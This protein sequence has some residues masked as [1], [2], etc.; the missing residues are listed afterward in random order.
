MGTRATGAFEITGW[1]GAPYDE[2]EGATLS[3][4]RLTKTYRGDLEGESA[5]DLLFAEAQEEGSGA[6]SG[7]ERFVGGV[8]GRAGSFV[9]QHCENGPGGERPDAATLGVVAGSGTGELRGLSGEARIVVD[10]EGNHAFT[11]YYDLG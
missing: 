5:T 6:Y 9:L 4:A 2:R 7:L 10:G 1:D 11:L 8:H 3:R